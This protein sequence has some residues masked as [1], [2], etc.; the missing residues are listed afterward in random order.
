MP[1]FFGFHIG[2]SLGGI[3]DAIWVGLDSKDDAQGWVCQSIGDGWYSVTV[4][5]DKAFASYKSKAYKLR[6]MITNSGKDYSADMAMY[7]DNL[8]LGISL[9]DLGGSVVATEDEDAIRTN[10]QNVD[11]VLNT[12]TYDEEVVSSNSSKSLKLGIDAGRGETWANAD[13]FISELIGWKPV[14]L[15]GKTISFDIKPVNN[16]PYFG[17]AIER[18]DVGL[19]EM[20]YVGFN[21]YDTAKGWSC[22]E[23]G[24]GWYKVIIDLDKAF[25][26]YQDR[27]FK[28]RVLI[29]NSG[30]DY[31]SET[32]VYI[33]NLHLGTAIA[34]LKEGIRTEG[35]DA[36]N[37]DCQ[38]GGNLNTIE[39]STEQFALY[40]EHSLKL[41]INGGRGEVWASGDVLIAALNQWTGVDLSGKTIEFDVK[42]INSPTFFGLATEQQ[43]VGLSEFIYIGFDSADDAKG[44]SCRPTGAGWYHVTV[45]VEKAFPNYTSC[46]FKFRVMISNQNQDQSKETMVY[47]DNLKLD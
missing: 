43:N 41:G 42:P 22:Q 36:I 32:V 30:Q 15:V 47:I 3:S 28:F 14:D 40:S 5:V 37:V 38:D 2:D 31:A 24:N 23:I 9:S 19:A 13:I 39:Y 7:I 12:L 4:E 8:N 11:N 46:V 25:G 33:D 1:T 16:T 45:D 6:F 29:S 35:N 21:S 20:I 44:W 27:V 34:E 10:V 18:S 17:F 26:G